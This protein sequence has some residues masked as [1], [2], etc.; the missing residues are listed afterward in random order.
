[1]IILVYIFG[2]ILISAGA[3]IIPSIQDKTRPNN[4][5]VNSCPISETRDNYIGWDC[6]DNNPETGE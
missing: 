6:S 2:Y 5:L 4:K 1:M 3:V